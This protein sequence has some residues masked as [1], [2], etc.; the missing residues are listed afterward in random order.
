MKT[1]KIKV[2]ISIFIILNVFSLS[3][4]FIYNFQNYRD[5]QVRVL[6]ILNNNRIFGKRPSESTRFIDNNIYTVF[7][8][9]DEIIDIISHS[10]DGN[11]DDDLK[12]LVTSIDTSK[13]VIHVGNL[14]RDKYSY[15]VSNNYMILVDCSNSNQR[16]SA[17][18]RTTILLFIIIEIISYLISFYL[19]RWIIKPAVDAF[20][21]QKRFIAD[22]SHEL[23]T[24]LAVIMA[25]ADSLSQD[26]NEEKWISN[27]Q[28]ESE[29]MNNLIK[30]LLDLSKIESTNTVKENIDISKLVEKCTIVLE[31]LMFEKNITLQYDINDNI[32]LN[33]NSDE[34][35]Q[36]VS[37]LLDNAIKHS[38][39]NGKIIVNL[40]KNKNSIILEVKNKGKSIEK[41]E[42]EKI[43][44]RFYRVDESRNRND[45]R[46][47]LGLAIAKSIVEKNNGNI[48]AHS[49]N[50]FTTFKVIFKN[51]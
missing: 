34:I 23:K 51:K 39:N 14:Y 32:Y 48:S 2:F 49:S 9:S 40:Y 24:P 29:R 18:Y 3:L 19:S 26:K 35:K 6:A 47:G 11:I 31:S 21:A 15:K 41:G 20:E 22:A 16:L 45:N 50:G 13:N 38:I 30:S 46:Y 1:L 12:E 44:E 7:F 33:C 27:I 8:R 43:F 25:S 10:N 5:E 17:V 42:E 28:N 37:I 4:L 36:L